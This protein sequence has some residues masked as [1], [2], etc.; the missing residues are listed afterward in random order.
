[1]MHIIGSAM[2]TKKLET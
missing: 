2:H 1:M